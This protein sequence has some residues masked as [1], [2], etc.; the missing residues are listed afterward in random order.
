MMV[1]MVYRIVSVTHIKSGD[2]SSLKYDLFKLN[3]CWFTK[4]K[5]TNCKCCKT[6]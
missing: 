4:F 3:S 5:L 1:K 6:R 2:I